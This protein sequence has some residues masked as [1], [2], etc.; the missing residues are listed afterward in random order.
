[1]ADVKRYKVI[2]GPIS[3][4]K[5]PDGDRLDIRL[6]QGEEIEAIGEPVEQNNYYW[7]QHAKGW[8]ALGTTMGDEMLMIDISSRPAD[9]PRTFRV[10]AASIS[11]RDKPNGTRL[12]K[13]LFR[14]TEIVG[15]PGS[16]TEAGGYI[17]WKHPD[18]W[19]AECS[20]NGKEIFM[21][22]I[23]DAPATST[24]NPAHRQALPETY[25]GKIMLQLAQDAKV[26]AQPNTDPRGMVIITLKRGKTVT[27]DMDT[28]TEADGYYWARHEIGWSALQSIDG[29]TKFLAEPGSIPG[30]IAIGADGPKASDLPGLGATVT[31]MPVKLEDIQWFQYY[32]NNMWAY[33]KGKD[34]GYDRYSQGLHGGL[35]FGNSARAGVPVYAGVEGTFVKTEYPKKNNTRM[36][37]QVG[38]YVFMYQH[39]T[40]ARAFTP[41]Q[42]ISPDVQIGNIEHHTIDN[43]WDHLHFEVRFMNDWI[44]NPLL[45]MTPELQQQIITR[46]NP[47]KPNEGY[48]KTESELQFF[49]RS[50]KWKKWAAPLDQPNLKIAAPCVGPRFQ[51]DDTPYDEQKSMA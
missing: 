35:D 20:V 17:W 48:K 43:G 49:F 24:P 4:R 34:Y 27:V 11:I 21:K 32:G 36:L 47:E 33:T 40:N 6:G 39:I 13:K 23:F 9:A 29:K 41:G 12:P 26:R 15:E 38:D 50:P 18:G 44:I 1:M 10:W 45:L 3:I 8:S 37:I 28:L 25:K 16:R 19:S 7:V 22:E 42:K 31:Q 30:L 14:G 51:D 46:F 5:E 2:D